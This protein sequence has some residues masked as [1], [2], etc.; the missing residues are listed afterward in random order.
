MIEVEIWNN[1]LG[2]EEARAA[3]QAV[4]ERCVSD[5]RIVKQMETKI[6]ELLDIPFVIA[7]PNGTASILLAL[8][9]AGICPGDEV[10]VPDITFIATANAA[11]ALGAVVVVADTE[12][13]VPVISEESVMRLI[14]DRTRAVIPVHINGH[15]ACTKKLS[16]KLHEKGIFII[17]DA[18]QAFMSGSPGDYAG[19]NAD[20]ACYSTGITKMVASGQGGFVTTRNESLYLKM[21]KLKTQGLDS[22]FVRKDYKVAG[23]NLKMSDILASIALI[24]LDKIKSKMEHMWEIYN[25]YVQELNEVDG[26][27]FIPRQENELPW[28]T[29]IMCKNRSEIKRIMEENGLVVREIGDCLHRASY[30]EAR[31][32]YK[33]SGK[34]EE[35]ILALPSGP[36]QPMEN[37]LKVC[38][39]LK[40]GR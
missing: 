11:K 23:L 4:V 15:I 37:V 17:D 25:Q 33:H 14:T 10:I 30:L 38:K 35:Q 13:D 7:A 32:K 5:G 2:E 8:M 20:M 6:A 18:C 31:D 24:Q 40:E 28:M 3:Y 19:N 1:Q 36:D 26:I 29:Y 12:K 34:F 16:A 22:V 9:A 39:I 21:K 27:Q